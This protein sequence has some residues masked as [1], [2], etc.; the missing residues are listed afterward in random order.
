[1]DRRAA[2]RLLLA[3]VR[4]GGAWGGV[5]AATS[6]L[7]AAVY[8]VLPALMGRAVDAVLGRGD[9][10]LWLTLTAVA[11][12]LLV[13]CDAAD[14]YAGAVA[15][16]RSTA[17]L[18]H[19]LLGHILDMGARATRRYTPGDLVARLVGNTARVEAAPRR[20]WCGG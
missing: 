8:V 7:L 15:N 20:A 18:R 1:M 13:V 19:T 9:S 3:A 4:R 12:V 6:L 14:D 10:S 11:V 2:D 16:S 17:W 5:L